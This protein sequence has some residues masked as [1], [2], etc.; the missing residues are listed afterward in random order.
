[1]KSENRRDVLFLCQ[2]FYPEHNSSATLPFDTACALAA[3]GLTVDALVGMPHEYADNSDVPLRETVSGVSIRRVRYL[4]PARGSRVGRLLNFFSFTAGVLMRLG[5]LKHHRAV[6]VY[7]NPPILPLAGWLAERLF[8]TKL[9][10]VA[11]DVY[12]EIALAAGSIRPGGAIDRVMRGINRRVFRRASA[13]AVLSEEM[14]DTLARLRPALDPDR[15]HV[16]PNWAHESAPQTTEQDDDVLTVGYFGNLGVVQEV[17]TLLAA[18]ERLQDDRR[19]RFLIAG[20]GSKLEAMRA[21]TAEIASVRVEGFLTD[22]ALDRALGACDCCLVTLEN[23]MRGLCMPSKYYSYL[24]AGKA[25]VSIMEP[26][27][28]LS[29]EVVSER[30]GAAIAPGDVNGLCKTLTAMAEDLAS[31]HAAGVRAALLYR[32]RYARD[33]ALARYVALVRQVLEEA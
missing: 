26:E 3:A 13:V 20:H 23:G 16:L 7:S 30:L 10:F 15:I 17:D 32:E 21:R 2:Y 9:I 6:I 1:M 28:C 18:I 12:P 29:R 31:V 33:I 24:Q 8:K 14:R 22:A 4:H 11:Y 5:E 25:V 27:A 19:I